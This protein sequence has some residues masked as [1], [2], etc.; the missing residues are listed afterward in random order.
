MNSITHMTNILENF[1]DLSNQLSDKTA[2]IEGETNIT[3]GQLLE[4]SLKIAQALNERM[5]SKCLPVAVYLP[6]GVYSVT[7]NIGIT[8]SGNAYMNLDIKSPWQRIA[9]I[10]DQIDPNLFLTNRKLF[11]SLADQGIPTS[12]VMVVEDL[13]ENP[14]ASFDLEAILTKLSQIIDTDPYCIINTSGSTGTPKGVVLN[15]RSFVDFCL[16]AFNTFEFGQD[17]VVGSLSPSFFDIYSFE[18][19]LLVM[20]GV[21]LVMIPEHY[22]AFPAKI[23]EYLQRMKA[24]FIFWVP[25][26]MTNIS[27]MDILSRIRLDSLKLVWF[28]GEVF[29]TKHL[30]YWRKHIPQAQFVNMYGPIE[31]TLDCVYHVVDEALADEEPLPIGIPCRNTD[32]LIL[33]DDDKPARQGETGE[34]CVRGSS[35]A[36]GYYN[37]LEKTRS[38][39]VQNPLNKSYPELIYRTG[40]LVYTNAEGKIMFIGRKDFQIKHQGYRIELGEIENAALNLDYIENACVIYDQENR[41]IVLFYQAGVE[42]QVKKIRQDLASALP[43]YMLPSSFIHLS[44]LPMNPNGKI[45]RQGLLERLKNI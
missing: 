39:F 30:N 29:P 12:K 24:T 19:C 6:K 15:H 25:T 28:A 22:S 18:L 2:V 33:T 3:F 23:I 42:E 36:M 9:K 10:A 45:D 26:I 37:D 41:D 4:E 40:D 13:L 14:G 11:K 1:I 32:I 38:A 7:S 8:F 17:E 21:T 43:K 35:L 44:Q 20:R 16:W 5:A 31:I 27:N 34:L